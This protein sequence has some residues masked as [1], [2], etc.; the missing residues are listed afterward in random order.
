MAIIGAGPVG[1]SFSAALKH[2]K[3]KIAIIDRLP[4]ANNITDPRGL[5]LTLTS[6]NFFNNIGL[7]P[8]LNAISS[9]I[10]QV[11][12]STKGRFVKTRLFA[13][14]IDVAAL[15]YV[16][17]FN[18]LVNSLKNVANNNTSYFCPEEILAATLQEDHWQLKLK[19]TTINAKLL[20]G[21][22]GANSIV[23]KLA[24]ISLDSVDYQ[25]SAIISNIKLLGD[26]HNIAYER[27]SGESAIAML[28]FGQKTM[29]FVW[30]LSSSKAAGLI[31]QS[32]LLNVIQSEF[33]NKLGTLQEMTKPVLIPL[34][35]SKAQS[36]I[37]NRLVL[38]GNAAN[39][40]HPIAA[41]G[42]NLGLRDVAALAELIN[43][44][45]DPGIE[46]I[47][48]KYAAWRARDHKF[49]NKFTDNLVTGFCGK[50]A[51]MLSIDLIPALKRK[52]IKQAC[53][54]TNDLPRLC[55]G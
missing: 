37:A 14:D 29:K 28:P 17:P 52:F 45:A 34:K 16:V 19:H 32:N 51:M 40:M 39:T 35:S 30:S 3:L 33:G 22:D 54:L 31:K 55:R 1:L 42:L 8:D 11:Q 10:K 23:R 48:N 26:H 41:Q 6:Y 2:S 18:A 24:N 36:V 47:L 43:N 4:I 12:V 5:A 27:F 49:I 7:W 9:S 53:G 38:I 46:A 50:N 44:V 25:Q 13:S 21:A 20:V 15:G